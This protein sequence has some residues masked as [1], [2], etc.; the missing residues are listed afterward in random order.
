MAWY[1]LGKNSEI[2]FINDAGVSILGYSSKKEMIS[3]GGIYLKD[4]VHPDDYNILYDLHT[5]L[6]K[7]G[8]S[9]RIELRVFGNK[10][11]IKILEGIISLEKAYSGKLLFHFAF[12]NYL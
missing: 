1:S 2:R 3:K 10:S 9:K 7:L 5:K 6:K 8:D 4:Y 12:E 11:E